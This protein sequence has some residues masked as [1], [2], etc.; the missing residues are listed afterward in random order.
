[1]NN[2][3]CWI[4]RQSLLI[5]MQLMTIF[6]KSS[7]SMDTTAGRFP[8]ITISMTGC[9]FRKMQRHR[10]RNGAMP[11]CL[12]CNI[13]FYFSQC[14]DRPAL[15]IDYTQYNFVGEPCQMAFVDSSMFGIP[16]EG[17]DYYQN[18]T[19]SQPLTKNPQQVWQTSRTLIIPQ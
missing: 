2:K 6:L 18:G 15:T 5:L 12:F 17:Y 19:G 16:F 14:K 7:N 13:Q 9:C 4:S 3:K 8:V 1:M 11:L 10:T